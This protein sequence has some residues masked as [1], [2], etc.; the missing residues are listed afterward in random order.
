[1]ILIIIFHMIISCMFIYYTRKQWPLNP[2]LLFVLIQ[3]MFF[4]GLIQFTD[5]NIESDIVHLVIIFVGMT[6]FIMA[7]TLCNI[8]FK[9]PVKTV[10]VWL[11]LPYKRIESNFQFNILIG[12]IIVSAILI[13]SIYYYRVG[14]NLFIDL[15]LSVLQ[16]QDPLSMYSDVA[17]KRLAAYSGETYFAP[18]YTNQ[19]KNVLLP[20][21]I[22]YLYSRYFLLKKMR[23]LV[24]ALILSPLSLIFLLGTG[25]RGAFVIMTMVMFIFF[26]ASL[27]RKKKKWFNIILCVCFIVV[28]SFSSYLIGRSLSNLD[29]GL[30][31]LKILMALPERIFLGNQEAAV[32]GFHYL[33][34]LPTQYGMDWINDLMNLLPFK[35]QS[36]INIA[37]EVY[38]ILFGTDRGT[39]P[40]SIWGSI[41]YNFGPI[42]NLV[43][44]FIMGF[45]YQG[46]YIRFIRGPKTLFRTLIYSSIT[47]YL[48]SWMAGGPDTLVNIG[49]ATIIILRIIE[50]TVCGR[51]SPKITKCANV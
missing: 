44:P 33:Y 19:F 2:A 1:M 20:L 37:S 16:G 31:F 17:G 35:T 11:S 21:L 18:G 40:I 5:M 7:A 49:L 8:I 41:W 6:Q 34:Q 27:T 28:F 50:Y 25:Q 24:L 10:K 3:L 32:V 12:V 30:D 4:S 29:S 46:L 13:S 51:W 45:I 38:Y 36:H 14:Y 48:G 26:N 42:G 15:T 39:A 47:V 43:I 22:C 23:N 9:T